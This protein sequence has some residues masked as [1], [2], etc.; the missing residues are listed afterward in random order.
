MS[1]SGFPYDVDPL[2]TGKYDDAWQ[3][4]GWTSQNPVYPNHEEGA[5]PPDGIK[6]V[7]ITG[8]FFTGENKPL[9]GQIRFVPKER[10][11]VHD[12]AHFLFK[13]IKSHIKRG[14]VSVHLP[15][16]DRGTVFIYRVHQRVGPVQ[17]VYDLVL[18]AE[19][20]EFDLST[21]YDP[22][23]LNFYG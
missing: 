22:D 10:V 19:M 17:R 11:H 15:V 2:S 14:K 4:E 7:E 21:T 13:T 23:Y 20:T 18:N 6:F 3:T 9:Y 5:T 16:P 8:A 12:G 1:N